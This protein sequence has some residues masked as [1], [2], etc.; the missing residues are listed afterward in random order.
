[1][2]GEEETEGGGGRGGRSSRR[3]RK[4]RRKKKPPVSSRGST[5][6]QVHSRVEALWR[7]SLAAA[8]VVY[9]ERRVRV[10]VRVEALGVA[11]VLEDPGPQVGEAAVL[12]Q[13]QPGPGV[14]LHHVQ[15]RDGHSAAHLGDRR[16]TGGSWS[17]NQDELAVQRLTH[18]RELKVINNLSGTGE[19]G[20]WEYADWTANLLDTVFSAL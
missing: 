6:M 19:P 18:L 17:S 14:A 9:S 4:W 2:E 3:D 15:G 20:R 1:M 8:A 5:D 13:H 12:G 11:H 10:D 7:R 16:N